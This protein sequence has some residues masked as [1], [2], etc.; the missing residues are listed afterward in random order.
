[1]PRYFQHM[2]GTAFVTNAAQYLEQL[3]HA[4]VM[5]EKIR[6]AIIMQAWLDGLIVTE[7]MDEIIVERKAYEKPNP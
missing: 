1:M 7:F 2:T 6:S 4:E 3:R 5:A